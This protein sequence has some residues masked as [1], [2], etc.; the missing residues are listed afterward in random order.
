[1]FELMY[2][3]E[4]I[5]LAANQVGLPL[6]FFLANL[7]KE[8][9]E[10]R[11]EYVFINPVLKNRRGS[12]LDDEGCL[13][14]PTMFAPVV[15]SSKVTVEAFDLQ[16]NLF[17]MRLNDLAARVIQHENDHLDGVLFIDKIPAVNLKEFE[18]KLIDLHDDF[19]ADQEGRIY[20]THQELADRLAAIA[21][22]GQV[23]EGF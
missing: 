15:R 8:P 19:L 2:Q 7:A 23:P 17:E 22:S 13:S 18:P 4:G 10:N 12:E 6:R 21:A 9:K 3:S 16:G 20:P 11:E 5:G 14:F 1:M